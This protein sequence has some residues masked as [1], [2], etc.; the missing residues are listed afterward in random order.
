MLHANAGLRSVDISCNPGRSE[1]HEDAVLPLCHALAYN[2]RLER[3][4]YAHGGLSPS[5]GVQLGHALAFSRSLL[6]L[7]V[8]YNALGD[9][10]CST[11]ASALRVNSS[12]RTLSLAANG[13][14]AIGASA[15]CDLL[16]ACQ[17]TA[18]THGAG[19]EAAPA[20]PHIGAP[21]SGA[22]SPLLALRLGV[23]SETDCGADGGDGGAGGV[24]GSSL[25][26][27]DL[28][29]NDLDPSTRASL[30]AAWAQSPRREPE[31]LRL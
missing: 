8:S 17:D 25:T 10:G 5:A 9:A 2:D 7:D 22:C 29:A 12:L 1:C 16:A 14:S 6:D 31:A 3:L 18:P 13:I 23:R 30:I 28:A 15:L 4:R 19:G 11:I 20:S 27:L 21:R 26:E 24:A